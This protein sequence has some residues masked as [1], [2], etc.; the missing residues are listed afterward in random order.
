MQKDHS[1]GTT[2]VRCQHTFHDACL[3]Y[4]DNQGVHACPEC[5][6]DISRTLCTICLELVYLADLHATTPCG[7]HFHQNCLDQATTQDMAGTRPRCPN[8]RAVLPQPT[9]QY[10]IQ[11]TQTELRLIGTALIR[12]HASISELA[13]HYNSPRRALQAAYERLGTR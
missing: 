4:L 10:H 2:T 9:P 8:C 5:H 6:S 7:H 12:P 1:A 3:E 11:L 13:R